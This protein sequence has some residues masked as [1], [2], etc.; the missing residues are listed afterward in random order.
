MHP[1]FT[2]RHSEARKT[3]RRVRRYMTAQMGWGQ[4]D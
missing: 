3:Y 4:A 1:S 2:I